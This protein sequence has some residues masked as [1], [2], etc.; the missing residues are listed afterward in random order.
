MQPRRILQALPGV[1][2]LD[3]QQTCARLREAGVDPDQVLMDFYGKVGALKIDGERDGSPMTGVCLL[4][5]QL[6]V[7]QR[8]T[9]AHELGHILLGHAC[10][11]G[12]AAIAFASH[13]LLPRAV[14]LKLLP[15]GRLLPGDL[16]RLARIFG[17]SPRVI[18][19]AEREGW[20]YPAA[21]TDVMNRLLERIEIPSE[22]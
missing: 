21:F 2:V 18:R 7:E 6:P 8:F 3:W 17:V 5:G 9:L 13:L 16:P 12:E 11:S 1:E 10:E 4:P 15:R 14:A 20:Q 22:V 19:R